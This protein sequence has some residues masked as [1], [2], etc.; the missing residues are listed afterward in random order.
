ML[1]NASNGA[2]LAPQM[3]T[4][5]LSKHPNRHSVVNRYPAL[6]STQLLVR[7]FITPDCC[8]CFG[9]GPRPDWNAVHV[10]GCQVLT[11]STLDPAGHGT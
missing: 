11:G 2:C 5:C 9:P 3:E 8:C 1:R 6:L 4:A 7:H 10:T